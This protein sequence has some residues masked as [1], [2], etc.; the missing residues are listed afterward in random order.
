M[1]RYGLHKIRTCC[2]LLVY[3][4]QCKYYYAQHTLKVNIT[5]TPKVYNIYLY[6]IKLRDFFVVSDAHEVGI[7]RL[8]GCL[9]ASYDL[10]SYKLR[11]LRIFCYL[12]TRSHHF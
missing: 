9:F 5:P 10:V 8:T 12:H 3:Y 7:N 1:V 6:L 2:C 11:T 4:E